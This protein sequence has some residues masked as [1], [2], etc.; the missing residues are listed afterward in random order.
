MGEKLTGKELVIKVLED[1]NEPI[2]CSEIW[3]VAIKS[4]YAKLYAR[5][6]DNDQKKAQISSLLSTWSENENSPIIRYEKGYNGNP[7]YTYMLNKNIEKND[8]NNKR[9]NENITSQIPKAVR[10][11]VWMRDVGNSKSGKC[12][13]CPR[14]ITD[15]NFE[16]GHII[17]KHNNGTDDYDN[18]RAVCIP[19]NRSMKSTNLEDYKEKHYPNI[20]K[21]NVNEVTKEDAIQFLELHKPNDVNV[22][23]FNKAIEL[24]KKC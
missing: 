6:T 3:D 7:V 13:I 14:V 17:S 11:A 15:D 8:N 5:G 18:L 1:S 4:K 12:Y 9:S 19:C 16:A 2:T 21:S 10:D 20:I 23:F 22:K 24:L